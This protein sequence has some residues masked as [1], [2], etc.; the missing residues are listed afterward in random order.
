MWRN[1]INF[2][3]YLDNHL[4]NNHDNNFDNNPDNNPDNN[5]VNNLDT[6][7]NVDMSPFSF[8]WYTLD[9]TYYNQSPQPTQNF[10]VYSEYLIFFHFICALLK[11][12]SKH[13]I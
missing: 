9:A 8:V 6:I 4:D 11:Y 12:T 1:D 13:F 7:D 2:D 3:N 10:W 5:L